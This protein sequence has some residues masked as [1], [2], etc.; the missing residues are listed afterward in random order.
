MRLFWT[1]LIVLM[2][3]FLINSK[4]NAALN[5]AG[6]ANAI[7]T[8]LKTGNPDISGQVETDLIASWTSICQGLITHITTSA[9]VNT[10]VT[11]VTSPA[12]IGVPS[13]ITAQ[14]GIGTIQ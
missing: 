5:A 12:V 13:T 2:A 1:F 9:V 3:T 6:C 11:G 14:P 4:A 8:Q 7:V 10:T